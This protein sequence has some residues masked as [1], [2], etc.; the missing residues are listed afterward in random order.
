MGHIITFQGTTVDELEKAFIDSINDYLNWCKEC[1]ESPEKTFSGNLRL[2]MSPE[3]HAY[4]TFEATKR[5]VS[6]NDLINEKLQQN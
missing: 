1:G 3:L 5:G 4:L 2:R 6:L